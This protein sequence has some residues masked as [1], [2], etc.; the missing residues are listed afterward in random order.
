MGGNLA[1]DGVGLKDSKQIEIETPL[2]DVT[3]RF[4]TN[5]AKVD[6]LAK[7]IVDQEGVSKALL[8]QADNHSDKEK[9][10]KTK[11]NVD[12]H[13]KVCLHHKSC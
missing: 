9:A 8:M 10:T 13:L 6:D 12:D 2:P 3:E 1:I 4:A 5:R 7:I 11:E